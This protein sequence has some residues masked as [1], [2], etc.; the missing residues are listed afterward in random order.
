MI[1]CRWLNSASILNSQK[2]RITFSLENQ[3][4]ISDLQLLALLHLCAASTP[5][6]LS[7]RNGVKRVHTSDSTL[8]YDLQCI[9]VLEIKANLCNSHLCYQ[10]CGFA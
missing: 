5:I 1:V 10:E 3:N 8:L 6:H 7:A 9:S 4:L 2:P